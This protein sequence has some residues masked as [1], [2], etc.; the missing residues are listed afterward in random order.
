[1]QTDSGRQTSLDF[2]DGYFHTSQERERAYIF[3][4]HVKT[5]LYQYSTRRKASGKQLCIYPSI[6]SMPST[7]Y[8]MIRCYAARK[9]QKQKQT[10]ARCLP[11][12]TTCHTFPT[13]RIC[14]LFRPIIPTPIDSNNSNVAKKKHQPV[15]DHHHP[16][17]VLFPPRHWTVQD[18]TQATPMTQ[19]SHK[20]LLL[21]LLR[22]R[23]PPQRQP[24]RLVRQRDDVPQ[25]LL[26]P[27]AGLRGGHGRRRRRRDGR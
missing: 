5:T 2:R 27:G 26:A 8:S 20:I 6:H 7:K 4:N 15:Q 17:P 1:M 23:P 19:K 14:S 10:Q 18:H 12:V 21:R 24:C 16:T 13:T 25:Q 22:V 3:N 9:K 11:P